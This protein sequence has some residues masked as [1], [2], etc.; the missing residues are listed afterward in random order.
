MFGPHTMRLNLKPGD[1][2]PIFNAH[3]GKGHILVAACGSD[4]PRAYSLIRAFDGHLRLHDLFVDPAYNR[5]GAGKALLSSVFAQAAGGGLKEIC[6]ITS[7]NA[8]WTVPFYK[9][10]GFIIPPEDKLPLHIRADLDLARS[11]EHISCVPGYFPI[12][13]MAAPV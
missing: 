2:T 5:Q 3:A 8:P 10:N 11:K 4:I 12:V 13:G 1:F 6:L 7:A 9:K